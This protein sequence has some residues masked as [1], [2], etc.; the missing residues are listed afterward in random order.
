[1]SKSKWPGGKMKQVVDVHDYSTWT[2]RKQSD[3]EARPLYKD[4]ERESLLTD[5][6]TVVVTEGETRIT[7]P[8]SRIVIVTRNVKI[9]E[10]S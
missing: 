4:L 8:L 3:L 9:E 7:L 2:A 10:E 5:L 1:M 6:R